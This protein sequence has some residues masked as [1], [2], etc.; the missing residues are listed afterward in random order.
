MPAFS[1]PKVNVEESVATNLVASAA[2]SGEW[3]DEAADGA[4]AVAED[5]EVARVRPGVHREDAGLYGRNQKSVA[6]ELPVGPFGKGQT[7]RN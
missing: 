3:T 7:L 4:D 1:Q 6:P 2:F 5:V